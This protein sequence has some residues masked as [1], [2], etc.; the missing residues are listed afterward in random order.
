MLV[1]LRQL[2][3][4]I[5]PHGW[6]DV[7]RQF[8]LFGAAYM[9]YRV[10]RGL[11]DA[12]T[13]TAFANARR[14]ISVERTLHL[15][16]EPSIQVWASGSHL[17]ME[18]ATWLYL[19]AQSTVLIGVLLYLYI[20]HNRSFYFVRNMLMIAMAI[21][22]VGYILFPTAP[23]RFMPE[24][25]FSDSIADLTGVPATS[26]PVNALFNPYAA[27][28][29]MHVGFA[30][31]LGWPLARLA[32]WRIVAAFWYLYPFVIAFVTIATANH[33]LSDAILGALTAGI[34]AVIARRLGRL[35][36]EDWG[37]VGRTPVAPAIAATPVGVSTT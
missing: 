29:S 16:V 3:A 25:G 21:A 37:F 17:L 2:R 28:P 6:P 12:R 27:I 31:M 11:A 23:P 9:L 22:L 32:R 26:A 18:V 35:R 1:R 34:S 19:N 4:R 20:I 36:P 30:L 5:L 33:F 13:V 7:V 14:L 15:F 24:W 8:L 10:A